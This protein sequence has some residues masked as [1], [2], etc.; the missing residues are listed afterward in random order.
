MIREHSLRIL[1]PAFA[2]LCGIALCAMLLLY[3]Q[4]KEQKWLARLARVVTPHEQQPSEQEITVVRSAAGLDAA[5]VWLR[6][7]KLF[8][9]DP[10]HQSR[11]ALRWWMVLALTLIVARVAVGLASALLGFW[12][13]LLLI[14]GWVWLSRLLFQW[15]ERK[16]KDKLFRQLPDALAMVVRAVRIGIPVGESIH[17]LAREGP[18][19]TAQEFKELSDQIRLGVPIDEALVQVATNNDMAEYRFFATALSLQRQS[20]GGLTET[21]ENLAD[22]IRK[23]VAARNRARALAAEAN[24]SAAILG[25]M[26]VVTGLALWV[27]NPE[28]VA[29][30]FQNPGGQRLLALATLLLGIGITAMRYTI[31]KTLS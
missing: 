17:V 25:C 31:N 1:L 15:F 8:G 6:L 22:V 23:R 2:G 14:P 11:Y 9:F 29:Y 27:I 10:D 26:P 24:T 7:A 16:H 12:A 19:P 21:L 28:Y 20:G 30:L 18:Q 5:S 3:A 13:Y 4:S